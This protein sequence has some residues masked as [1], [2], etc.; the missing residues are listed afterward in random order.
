[1]RTRLGGSR[2]LAPRRRDQGGEP[3]EQFQGRE[4]Q[5]GAAVRLR[6]RKPIDD[7][8]GI[9]LG[10]PFQSKGW[11]GTI[12]QQP[13][14][15]GAVIPGNPHRRIERK[16]TLL[17]GQHRFGVRSLQQPAAGKPPQHPPAHLRGDGRERLRGQG[18]G[19]SELDLTVGAALKYPV[20]DAAVE[21]DVAVQC[22]AKPVHEA[23]RPEPCARPRP[24]TGL[25]QGERLGPRRM[26]WLERL[27]GDSPDP[28]AWFLL[29]AEYSGR[30]ELPGEVEIAESLVFPCRRLLLGLEGFL[31]G[32]RAGVR[33]LHWC[34][35]HADLPDTGF[36]VGSAGLLRGA[37]P[38]LVLVRGHLERLDLPAPV[39]DVGLRSGAVS[40]LDL[41]APEVSPA[42]F[43]DLA[44][45]GR[46]P[47]PALLDRLRARLGADSVRGIALVGDHRP[48][49]A[50][51]WCEPGGA[52]GGHP[53][54]GPAALAAAGAHA[55]GC[56]DGHPWLDG[57]LDLDLGRER[58][59][60]DTGWWDGGEVAR[61]YFMATTA[62]SER[63]WVYRDLRGDRGWYLHGVMG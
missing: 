12:A 19:G 52:R 14:Q 20:E 4:G 36:T 3:V 62:R 33:R 7:P 34:L 2:A 29:P 1:M 57:P 28:R 10:Q 58:E 8:L 9:D 54:V 16:A 21:M 5:R 23:H 35:A 31:V 50:W 38:W 42:L 30:I 43:P 44:V 26:D 13:L 46:S 47:D 32:R 27:L 48:E 15:P 60:I 17:P 53:Q 56:P 51:R 59:R 25:L 18:L 22:R 61:D 40:T 24:G 6:F 37:D 11:P 39:W 41:A 55:P 63:F 45:P 49:L